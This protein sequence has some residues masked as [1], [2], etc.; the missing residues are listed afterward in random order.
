MDIWALLDTLEPQDSQVS[1]DAAA[2]Q[3]PANQESTE[4]SQESQEATDAPDPLDYQEI[5]VS[6]SQL[7]TAYRRLYL[8]GDF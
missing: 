4:A 1:E 7:F 2:H 8:N 3:D 6:N 5:S